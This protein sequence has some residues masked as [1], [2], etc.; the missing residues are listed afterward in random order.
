[1]TKKKKKMS[2]RTQITC[3]KYPV[4]PVDQWTYVKENEPVTFKLYQFS[5]IYERRPR[6][7]YFISLNFIS[8]FI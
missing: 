1:M 7:H 4:G 3:R 8:I 5:Q 6:I 2:K